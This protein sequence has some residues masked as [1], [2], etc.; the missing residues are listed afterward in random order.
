MKSRALKINPGNVHKKYKKGKKL[1]LSVG[2]RIKNREGTVQ[3]SIECV[4]A[5]V[6]G[7]LSGKVW[8]VQSS[9]GFS[10]HR[11]G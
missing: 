5:S 9:R 2:E 7:G 4:I 1:E 3:G 6:S 11:S 10:V 8:E